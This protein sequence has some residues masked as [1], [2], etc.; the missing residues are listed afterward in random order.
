HFLT[1]HPW[2]LLVQPATTRASQLQVHF[3]EDIVVLN[4]DEIRLHRLNG[5]HGQCLAGADIKTRAVAWADDV[6]PIKPALCQGSPV[7][8]THI[9]DSVILSAHIKEGHCDT[10][11]VDLLLLS[12]RQFS[13]LSNFDPFCHGC[14]VLLSA[15][16]LA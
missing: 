1:R 10:I 14:S 15:L 9:L 11:E 8:C 2:A 3:H 7:M 6:V 12:R 16:R 4:L 5:R 13:N